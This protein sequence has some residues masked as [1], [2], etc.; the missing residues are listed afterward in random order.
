MK[1]IGIEMEKLWGDTGKKK[2]G[3]S[4][5]EA[6]VGGRFHVEPNKTGRPADE[7]CK[8]MRRLNTCNI[9]LTGIYTE[10]RN[11][12]FM[13]SGLCISCAN[14]SRVLEIKDLLK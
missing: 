8:M 1:G 4:E 9:T 11:G 14:A 6:C 7:N 13:Q 10:G 12:S 5:A 3:E 2:T